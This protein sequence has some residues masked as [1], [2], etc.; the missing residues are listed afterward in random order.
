MSQEEKYHFRDAC[1]SIWHRRQSTR[2]FVGLED[3]QLLSMID[4]D[5][6][7]YVEYDEQTKIPL[8]L[9]EAAQDVGQDYKTA[10]VTR[11]LARLAH[12]PAYVLLYHLS[13]APNPANGN[14]S[15]IDGFR[16]MRLNPPS[17]NGLISVTPEQWAHHLL[18]MRRE[19]CNKLDNLDGIL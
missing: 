11:Q 19:Q 4:L 6:V 17:K 15:D 16:V 18:S 5:A 2:R 10:T 8:A 14:Y 3:A 12:L 13:E 7:I 9:I 1:Y